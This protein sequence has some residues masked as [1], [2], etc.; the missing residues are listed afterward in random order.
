MLIELKCQKKELSKS[1]YKD[2]KKVT[3]FK[4]ILKKFKK[5]VTVNL[6]DKMAKFDDYRVSFI[7]LGEA[8]KTPYL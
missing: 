3:D 7:G 5:L 4:K 1:Q 8:S 6:L 2:N